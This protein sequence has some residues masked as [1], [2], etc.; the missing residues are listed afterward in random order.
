MTQQWTNFHFYSYWLFNCSTFTLW[1]LES[2]I[3]AQQLSLKLPNFLTFVSN[4]LMLLVNV[5]L[6]FWFKISKPKRERETKRQ[7]ERERERERDNERKRE[8]ERKRERERE[9]EREREKEKGISV[10]FR[11]SKWEA[12]NVVHQNWCCSWVCAQ[13]DENQQPTI[14]QGGHFLQWKCS[15]TKLTL[16]NS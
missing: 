3:Y 12:G 1:M 8:K 7:I 4:Y 10:P 13:F 6:R 11:K 14:I 2:W 5:L 15:D 9:I 16:E